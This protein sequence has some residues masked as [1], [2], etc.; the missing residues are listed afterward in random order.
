MKEE[1]LLEDLEKTRRKF[2]IFKIKFE[3]ENGGEE[4]TL[5]F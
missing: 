5:F 4:K 2:R 1:N 3:C